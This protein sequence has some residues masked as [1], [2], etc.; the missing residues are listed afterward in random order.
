MGDVE[1]T[2]KKVY[3]TTSIDKMVVQLEN[4]LGWVDFK[5]QVD[6][7]TAIRGPKYLSFSLTSEDSRKLIEAIGLTIGDL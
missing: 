3:F 2:G 5:I 7:G 6:N 4:N 1:E